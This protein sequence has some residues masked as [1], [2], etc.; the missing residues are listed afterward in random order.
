MTN[1]IFF[2]FDSV[3]EDS[4]KKDPTA[5]NHEILS[6]KI[7]EVLMAAAQGDLTALER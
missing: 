7:I 4:H 6:Q 3:Q 1:I 2:S 5:H